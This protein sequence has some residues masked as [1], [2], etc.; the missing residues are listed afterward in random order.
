MER[1]RAKGNPA[2][3]K[4]WGDPHYRRRAIVPSLG[5]VEHYLAERYLSSRGGIFLAEDVARVH[6]AAGKAIKLLQ[7]FYVPEDEICFYLFE[8]ESAE[9]VAETSV[10]AGLDLTRILRVAVA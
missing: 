3:V 10:A 7:T 2:A 9:L 8:S 4:V 6:E 1:P 5:R